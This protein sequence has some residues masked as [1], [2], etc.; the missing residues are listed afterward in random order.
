MADNKFVA[1]SFC[2]K[3]V[4]EILEKNNINTKEEQASA[5]SEKEARE[6]AMAIAEKFGY[7]NEKI[8]SLELE[9][10]PSN[11][12]LTWYVEMSNKLSLSFDAIGGNNLNLHCDNVLYK[13]LREN[14][15]ELS[16]DEKI[17]IKYYLIKGCI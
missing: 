5:M 8:E 17:L 2:R 4:I 16:N 14:E 6:K 11:Y 9:K 3:R 10:N 15:Y 7:K 12:D 13:N 1:G